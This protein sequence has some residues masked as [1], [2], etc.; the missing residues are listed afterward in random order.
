MNSNS[1]FLE[2]YLQVTGFILQLDCDTTSLQKHFLTLKSSASSS[3][4]I[5][6]QLFKEVPLQ[7]PFFNT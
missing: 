3:I 2:M 5:L 1:D 6:T 4:S 7:Q